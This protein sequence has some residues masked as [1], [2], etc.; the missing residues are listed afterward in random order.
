MMTLRLLFLLACTGLAAAGHA[1]IYKCPNGQFQD[2]P[3]D[4]AATEDSAKGRPEVTKLRSPD[5]ACVAVG[6]EAGRIAKARSEG[7]SMS[8]MLADAEG[9]DVPYARKQTQKKLITEVFNAQGTPT[10]IASRIEAEC[11]KSRKQS[12]PGKP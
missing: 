1:A 7:S 12:A 6:K 10:Q 9:Q 4:K 3:C 2:K 8:K 5:E 11:V